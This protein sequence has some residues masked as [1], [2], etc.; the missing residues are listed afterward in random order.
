MDT[1][2]KAGLVKAGSS[3]ALNCTREQAAAIAA[4]VNE[5]KSS[6]RANA[7][8]SS[9]ASYK[10]YSSVDSAL[11]QKVAFAVQNGFVP[12]VSGQYLYPKQA[13]TRGEVLYMLEKALVLSGE[14]D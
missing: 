2:I 13:V 1:A 11:A 8:A 6:Q 4:A 7:S 14:I 5:I 9:L 10:D 12:N 3:G